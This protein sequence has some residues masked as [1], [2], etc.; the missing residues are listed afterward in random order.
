MTQKQSP[1]TSASDQT[2]EQTTDQPA[3]EQATKAQ[4]DKKNSA[5]GSGFAEQTLGH[6]S[7]R[8]ILM[9]LWGFMRPYRMMFL[10]CLLMLPLLSGFSLLQPWLL[11]IAID[12]YLV[13]RQ[14]DGI[15]WVALAFGATIIG[16]ALLGFLQFYLMQLAGQ[17][18]LRDLRNQL[19]TH[20]Q[21][22]STSFFKRNPIGRL[23]ARMTT[24]VE[25]LQEALSSG[26]VTM[27]GDII[28]LAAIVVILLYKNW[29][30]ALVSFT[31]VPVLLICTSIFRHLLRKAFREVRVKIARL[32]AHLQESV[33]G[34][35][36]IQL[37]VRENV[38]AREYS[39]IND[40]HRMANIRSIRYDAMLY[41]LV[42][43]VGSI[44]LGAIIWYGSGQALTGVVT[45]GVLVAF[46]EYMQ[47]FFVPI[48]DLAQKYNLLQSAIASSE[49]VF[50]LLDTDEHL[51]VAE[52]PQPIPEEEFTIE[53]K[54]VWFAYIEENWILRGVSFTI[55]PGEKLAVV[56]HT[57]AGK[58][59]IIALLTRLYDINKGQILINGIDIREFDPKEYRKKFAVV[60]QDVF[61]FQGSIQEN[62][63]LNNEGMPF[64]EIQDAAIT[65]HAHPMIMRLPDGY[66]H[67]I[68]ERGSNL[69]AGEKQLLA[70]ARAL[71]CKPEVLILDEATANVDT[72]TEALIQDA[73]EVLMTHQTSLVI[74]HRLSTIQKA[75][76]ILVLHRG[77]VIESGSH[78][79]LLAQDGHY[80]MLYR[81]QYAGENSDS[82][83]SITA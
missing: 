35:A 29:Q 49:R 27:I 75:D 14:P 22:L 48:R 81:L 64:D 12:D 80:G 11:Q 7:D 63:A 65:V 18:A 21:G 72:D 74:A 56:G 69:S 34:I 6:Y 78:E 45:L 66:Q 46:I 67:Q 16:R 68:A 44:T 17:R 28:T 73:V 53:F 42:E 55:N 13:P 26:I 24:D 60:L 58:S 83:A 51:P 54:D 82:R 33:T 19:F 77:Q 5:I 40:D 25:S 3:P 57:G 30:L 71:V 79:Q 23:M 43:T 76:R 41:A 39:E 10:I 2:T 9:R 20:V 50:Q 4:P 52:K 59:T 32:Y 37:F 47:K 15:G 8:A 36:V 31:V 38:S 62:L 70:F 1:N 61:L